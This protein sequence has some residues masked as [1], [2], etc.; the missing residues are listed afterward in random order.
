MVLTSKLNVTWTQKIDKTFI[1]KMEVICLCETLVTAC[2][3]RRHNEGDYNQHFICSGNLN[4]ETNNIVAV[5]STLKLNIVAVTS[6]LKLT[7]L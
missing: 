3:G 4:S 6:T 2:K 5:T 1:L 7:T